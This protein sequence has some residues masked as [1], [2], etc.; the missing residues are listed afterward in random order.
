MVNFIN[1]SNIMSSEIKFR[2]INWLEISLDIPQWE[3]YNWDV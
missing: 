1:I 3:S 2:E